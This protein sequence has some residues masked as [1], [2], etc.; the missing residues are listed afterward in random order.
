[1]QEVA[2]LQATTGAGVVEVDGV[3][4][5]GYL[6]A[7]LPG[8][9]EFLL[10]V[11]LQPRGTGED[12][13]RWSYCRVRLE[14]EAGERYRSVAQLQKEVVSRLATGKVDVGIAGADGRLRARADSCS[15]EH[16]TAD[17]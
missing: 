14:L 7:L 15:E 11:R 1:M 16:P 9:H 6:L 4:T 3:S 17:S 2:V 8:P 12:S 13:Q 5:S 10:R